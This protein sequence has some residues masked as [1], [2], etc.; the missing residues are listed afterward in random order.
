[1]WT[2][3]KVL[4]LSFVVVC[5]AGGESAWMMGRQPRLVADGLVSHAQNWGDNQQGVLSDEAVCAAFRERIHC[6]RGAIP[7]GIE[8]HPP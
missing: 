7:G 6:G 2:N 5:R 3:G 1:M 8:L 4:R